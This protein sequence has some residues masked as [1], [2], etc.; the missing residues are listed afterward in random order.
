MKICKKIEFK[1]FHIFH[2]GNH[3]V[4]KMASLRLENKLDFKRY[5]VLSA[6]I[7]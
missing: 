5:N 7:K 6:V 3:Y 4:D 1:V 2:E